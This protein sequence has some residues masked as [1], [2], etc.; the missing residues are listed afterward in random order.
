M[1]SN[2]IALLILIV[3]AIPAMAQET[4][5]NDPCGAGQS[6][7]IRQVAGPE[8]SG[9]VHLMRCDGVNWQQ[10]M[11]ILADG[12]V[13]I[14]TDAPD[15]KLDVA[16]EVKVGNT[17]GSCVA[18]TEGALRYNTSSQCLQFCSGAAWVCLVATDPCDPVNSPT[19][20]TTCS[21]GSIY[22]GLSPDGDVP[23]YITPVDAPSLM[24]WNDGVGAGDEQTD[25]SVPKCGWPYTAIGCISGS[26]NTDILISEDSNNT[27]PGS[28]H[29]AARYCYCLGKPLSGV[30]ASDP[31]SGAEAYGH[32][33]WYLASRN[34]F[35]VMEDNYESLG[36]EEEDKYWTSSDVT[37]TQRA[38][39]ISFIDEVEDRLKSVSELVRCTRKN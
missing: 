22:A 13:G 29:I 21:D 5:P 31:T 27:V 30:C 23:M 20:G 28:P 32:D 35:L 34:E 16:G 11:T 1:R 26:A 17:G 39:R 25:N 24:P 7:Y 9:V 36:F 12:K 10:Y 8:T 38:I 18:A 19:P 4:A 3:T 37:K 2:L 33:D 14:G 15:A 6:D